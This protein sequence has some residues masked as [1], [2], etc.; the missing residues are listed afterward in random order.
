MFRCSDTRLPTR[1]LSVLA[2]SLYP[3]PYPWGGTRSSS[4]EWSLLGGRRISSPS[5]TPPSSQGGKACSFQS[6]GGRGGK[7]AAPGPCLRLAVM[8]LVRVLLT[9]PTEQFTTCTTWIPNIPQTV[10][11]Q[12]RQAKQLVSPSENDQVPLQDFIRFLPLAQLP[13]QEK[14]PWPNGQNVRPVYIGAVWH[15]NAPQPL[16]HHVSTQ[17]LEHRRVQGLW[18]IYRCMDHK[19][20]TP[21]LGALHRRQESRE[22]DSRIQTRPG[23]LLAMWP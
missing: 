2:K 6:F 9:V 20:L 7:G 4:V 3:Q 18:A 11:E 17:P 19:E 16:N 14:I 10:P 8:E 15:K 22:S 21:Y 13:R 1:G 12:I 5:P 23:Y